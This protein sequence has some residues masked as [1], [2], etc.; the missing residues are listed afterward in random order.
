[1]LQILMAQLLFVTVKGK[2][3]INRKPFERQKRMDDKQL[4]NSS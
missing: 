2:M 1:M 3:E 4:S